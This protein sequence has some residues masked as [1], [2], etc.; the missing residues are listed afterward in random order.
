MEETKSTEEARQGDRRKLN[1]RVMLR[2]MAAVVVVFAVIWFF[3]LRHGQEVT[4][5]VEDGVVVDTPQS[6]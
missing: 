6:Q 5:N 3:F 2:S 1:W 4:E